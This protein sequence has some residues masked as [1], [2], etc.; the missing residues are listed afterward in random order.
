MSATNQLGTAIVGVTHGREITADEHEVMAQ[1]PIELLSGQAEQQARTP[2]PRPPPRGR[3]PS[4]PR[5]V[6]ARTPLGSR[7]A[8]D[9]ARCH[10]VD[11]IL[12]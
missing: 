2:A 5:P 4:R 11:A 7:P 8:S 10:V 1:V 9:N 3:A 12:P 6:D